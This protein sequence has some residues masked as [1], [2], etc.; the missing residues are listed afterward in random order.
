M[1]GDLSTIKDKI[2]QKGYDKNQLKDVET[3]L[4]HSINERASERSKFGTLDPNH[5]KRLA[6]ERKLLEFVQRRISQS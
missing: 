6:N 4:K 5:T 3:M 1:H 2:L